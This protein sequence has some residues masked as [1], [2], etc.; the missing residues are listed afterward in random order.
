[1]SKE[2]DTLTTSDGA[3]FK[4]PATMSADSSMSGK[5]ACSAA[6]V[7]LSSVVLDWNSAVMAYVFCTQPGGGAFDEGGEGGG[8]EGGGGDAPAGLGGGKGQLHP[9]VV[10]VMAGTLDELVICAGF[11]MKVASL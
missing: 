5:A 1:M 9:T 11:P 4:A 7:G 3:V 6:C 2:L 8:E 10:F